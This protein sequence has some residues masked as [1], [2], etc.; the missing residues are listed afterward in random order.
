MA[1]GDF[2]T[3]FGEEQAP[4]DSVLHG[5]VSGSA[6]R[7]GCGERNPFFWADAVVAAQRSP[8]KRARLVPHAS[9]VA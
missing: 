7:S 6:D 1:G 9:F 8:R 4:P 5:P 2:L 3:A